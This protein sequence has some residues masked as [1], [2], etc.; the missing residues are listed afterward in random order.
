MFDF[1]EELNLDQDTYI[2]Y[3]CPRCQWFVG[4]DSDDHE[5]LAFARLCIAN[6]AL[7]CRGAVVVT[8]EGENGRATVGPDDLL[9]GRIEALLR[10]ERRL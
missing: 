10:S 1:D 7:G 9:W 8:G 5:L 2:M 6:H 4:I 3:Q